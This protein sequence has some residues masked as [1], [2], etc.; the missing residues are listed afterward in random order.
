VGGSSLFTADVQL[1][2]L[3]PAGGGLLTLVVV[4]RLRASDIE[5]EASPTSRLRA[6]LLGDAYE[7]AQTLVLSRPDAS[8][9]MGVNLEYVDVHGLASVTRLAEGGL[10]ERSGRVAVGDVIAAVNGVDT[11]LGPHKLWEAMTSRTDVE[12]TVCRL[13][14]HARAP[15]R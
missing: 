12:L 10:A 1:A 8:V 11:S 14:P 3:L 7:P 15:A 5:G 4:R 6:D 2:D 13:K 9:S